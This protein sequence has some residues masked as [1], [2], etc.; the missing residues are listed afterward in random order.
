MD[1]KIIKAKSIITMNEKQPRAEAV[2]V[3]DGIIK[4]VGTLADCKAIA[5][6]ATVEDIGQNILMPG[7]IDSHS[8][9]LASG[10]SIM[11]PGVY[12]APWVAP[13]WDDVLRIFKETMKTNQ[14]A[15]VFFGFDQLL[16]G[17]DAPTAKDLDTIFGDRKALVMNNSGHGAYVTTAV[18]KELG[19]IENPPK[20]PVGGRFVRNT[21]GSL[22]GQAFEL[23]AV[24]MIAAPV[25]KDLGSNPLVQ[26]AKYYELMASVGITATSEMTYSPDF[27]KTYEALANKPNCPLRVSVYHVTTDATSN[28]DVTFNAPKGMLD[29]RGVKL[30]ADGSPWIGNIAISFKYLDTPVVRKAKIS[31][32]SGGLKEMNYSREQLDEVIAKHVAKGWQMAFH[33]NGD[34]SFDVVL[35]AYEAALKK[36]NL[37]GTDHR[38]RVE[39]IGGAQPKQLKRAGELGVVASM[40]P[41]QFYYWG[42]LLDG[43][44]FE[45]EIGSRW[46][47]FKTAFD[48]GTKPSFHNDGS[49]SPPNP[50]LN[51]QT[52]VSRTSISGTVHGVDEA[53][54]L[55]DALK[56][57]TINAAFSLRRDKE[58][59]SIEEGKFADFV[60]LSKD[61]YTAN[62]KKI[63][64]EVKVVDTWLNGKKIDIQ[65]FLDAVS[66]PSEDSHDHIKQHQIRRCC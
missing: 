50:L 31:L 26:V 40:G 63:A 19:W 30:W 8:H 54:S 49:V 36:N 59:G 3:S 22:N 13:R 64:D 7:F 51:I 23:P 34:L 1:L 4:K 15:M 45:K 14:N 6:S 2:L 61:P 33:V 20:D 11:P 41:F 10:L 47:R 66:H 57:Q 25:L 39:H 27:K 38:W 56:A 53:I 16:H 43:Q 12:I 18:L 37:M 24:L 46:Q 29:K 62:P 48:F 55:D 28:D 60:A 32:D 35:D 17:V 65:K 44:M 21:D 5:P 58:I 9:P 52:A 42:D